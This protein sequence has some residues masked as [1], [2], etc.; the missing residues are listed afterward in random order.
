MCT[1]SAAITSVIV[2]KSNKHFH[3]KLRSRDNYT[4]KW[5]DA[6]AQILISPVPLNTSVKVR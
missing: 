2:M 4:K 6:M 1:T 5:R 3:P